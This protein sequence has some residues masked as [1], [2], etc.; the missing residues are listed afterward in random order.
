MRIQGSERGSPFGRICNPTATNIS[1]RNA[2]IFARLC[3]LLPKGRKNYM[4]IVFTHRAGV[5]VVLNN[6]KTTITTKD[7]FCLR[8]PGAQPELSSV[9]VVV[10]NNQSTSSFIGMLLI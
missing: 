8:P 4:F 7:S 5:A 9:V 2:I 1:I 10:L 3:R 6:Q